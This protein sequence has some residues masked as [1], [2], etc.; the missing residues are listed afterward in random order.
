[1]GDFMSS[2]KKVIISLIVL[3]LI[4][5]GTFFGT[6]FFLIKKLEDTYSSSEYKLASIELKKIELAPIQVKEGKHTIIEDSNIKFTIPLENGKISNSSSGSIKVDFDDKKMVAY[7][8]ASDTYSD[9]L[10]KDL[11]PSEEKKVKEYFGTELLSSEYEFFKTIYGCKPSE[12]SLTS[13]FN[14][15]AAY[16]GGLLVKS[17]MLPGFA[18]GI[19][20]FETED[21]KGFMYIGNTNISLDF[22]S[23]D[24]TRYSI[25]LSNLTEEDAKQIIS[26]VEFK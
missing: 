16:N 23:D 13:S 11:K 6:K 4:G 17:M 19:Y 26:S 20:Y 18:K 9:E 24:S 1:M 25:L 8:G 10:T 12:L 22:Y 15:I 3:I 2:F 7:M 5:T 14:K 21:I